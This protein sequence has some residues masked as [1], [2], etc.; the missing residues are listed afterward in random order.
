MGLSMVLLGRAKAASWKGPV[1]DPLIIQPRSPCHNQDNTTVNI[2]TVTQRL[3][4]KS[5]TV[6]KF[7]AMETIHNKMGNS[8]LLDRFRYVTPISLLLRLSGSQSKRFPLQ[9]VL[10]QT[11][12]FHNS[13]RLMNI[14]LVLSPKQQY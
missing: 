6:A 2:A 14:P 8:Y 3:K 4:H 11:K 5:D 9:K 13:L 12:M 10:Q 1:I 7:F